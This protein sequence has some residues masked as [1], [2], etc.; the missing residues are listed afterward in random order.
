MRPV[1]DGD[2]LRGASLADALERVLDKGI[3]IDAHLRVSVASIHL[4][5][6]EACI[7]VA[8]VET[9]LKH[10]EALRTGKLAATRTLRL[11]PD[12]DLIFPEP[13][14]RDGGGRMEDATWFDFDDDRGPDPRNPA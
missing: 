10:E 8:S 5:D 13:Y 7:V 4:V 9:Y 12:G 3:V 14:R 6:V 2:D 11:L 1:D